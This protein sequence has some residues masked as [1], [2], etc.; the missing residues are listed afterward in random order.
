LLCVNIISEPGVSLG[1]SEETLDDDF[2]YE[3]LKLISWDDDVEN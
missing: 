3:K 2:Y 1:L